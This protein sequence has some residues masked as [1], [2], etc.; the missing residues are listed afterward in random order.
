MRAGAAVSIGALL[1][2]ALALSA[3][4]GARPVQGRAS[5]RAGWLVYALRELRFEAPATWHASGDERRVVL[6]PPGGGARLELS[7]PET[8]FPDERACLAAAEARLAERQVSLERA[9]RHA[10]R[11][12]GRPGQALEGDQGG[13]HVWAIAACDGGVQYRAFFTAATP[14]SAEALEV[15]RT[16]L[17][18]ARIGGEA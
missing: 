8:S 14:A 11:L 13:W 1:A 9:R 3:C 12:A 17:Q 10:T 5:G 15:W 18:L 2:G 6:E 16:L 7:V 4:A